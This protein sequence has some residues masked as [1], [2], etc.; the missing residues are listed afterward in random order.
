MVVTQRRGLQG[1]RRRRADERGCVSFGTLYL[2]EFRTLTILETQ[3]L[4]NGIMGGGNHMDGV[5]WLMVLLRTL[6]D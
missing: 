1:L 6:G 5:A 2:V 4:W 3:G